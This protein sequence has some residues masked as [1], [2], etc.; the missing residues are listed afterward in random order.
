MRLRNI[1]AGVAAA[2]ALSG[3][4]AASAATLLVSDVGVYNWNSVNTGL[5]SFVSTGIV[6]NNNLLVFCVDLQHDI[7]VTHYD[8]PLVFTWGTLDVDGAGNPISVADSNRIGQLADLGRSIL[9]SGDPD[10]SNDLT[11]IQAA[12]WSIEYHTTAVSS[13]GEINA[14]IAQFLTVQNN[15]HGRATA[16]IAHGPR[17]DG[18]Q[19][20]V[21]GGVPEP[22][23]WSLLI[24]GFGLAGAAL[25]RRRAAIA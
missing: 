12:I 1:L 24:A 3:A 25:R 10:F 19:N 13:D 11:A 17:A 14:E 16:L 7:G 5:G 9:G 22:G 6:F 8:P 2:A 23:A 21:T 20:M 18:T 4:G 15:G